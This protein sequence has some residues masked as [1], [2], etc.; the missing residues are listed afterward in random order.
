MSSLNSENEQNF[1]PKT[2][3]FINPEENTPIEVKPTQD[4]VF[5]APNTVDSVI[6]TRQSNSNNEFSNDNLN[7]TQPQ[8]F[9]SPETVEPK[10][11]NPTRSSPLNDYINKLNQSNQTHRS[12]PNQNYFEPQTRVKPES[13]QFKFNLDITKTLTYIGLTLG[14]VLSLFVNHWLG[15]LVFWVLGLLAVRTKPVMAWIAVLILL[16]F[17]LITFPVAN[18]LTLSGLAIVL[19]S[20]I[21]LGSSPTLSKFNK[22]LTGVLALILGLWVAIPMSQ[23]GSLKYI[24]TEYKQNSTF[25]TI[26]NSI[27]IGAGSPKLSTT[28]I[29]KNFKAQI[30]TEIAASIKDK[31]KL[32]PADTAKISQLCTQLGV[33]QNQTQACQNLDKTNLDKSID[34]TVSSQVDQQTKDLKD[35]FYQYPQVQMVQNLLNGLVKSD[36]SILSSIYFVPGIVLFLIYAFVSGL[37]QLVSWPVLFLFKKISLS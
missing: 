29:E 14:L 1:E 18:Y 8:T 19:L 30:S 12:T 15:L 5:F 3:S 34:T 11:Q 26:V 4:K 32:L 33:E 10:D 28:E 13:K 2:H 36:N 23:I 16:L 35:Q 6:S 31:T 37:L 20:A 25:Q 24:Q 27:Y 7:Y 22:Y 21:F 9:Q 17:I